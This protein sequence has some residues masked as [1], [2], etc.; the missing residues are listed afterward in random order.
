MTTT[1]TGTTTPST[2]A[3]R[4]SLDQPDEVREFPNGRLEVVTL[5]GVTLSR[6]TM[7]P[8]W[9]WSEHVRPIAGTDTCQVVHTGYSVSG[10]LR[11]RGRDGLEIEVRPG[12]AYSIGPG[13]DAWVVGD[14]PWIGVDFSPAMADFA[15]S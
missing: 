8:G 2:A 5:P 11:V 9:H 13:H 3:D 10:L 1:P 6:S 7:Q 15:K 14:E 4:Q 12:D